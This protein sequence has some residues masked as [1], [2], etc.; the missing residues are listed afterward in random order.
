VPNNNKERL[1]TVAKLCEERG[2]N[3][4]LVYWWI[5]NREFD[6]VRIGKKVLIPEVSF[7]IFIANHTEKRVEF[8]Q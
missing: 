6:V 3:P 2:L 8:D 4:S 1:L 7:N 5:R